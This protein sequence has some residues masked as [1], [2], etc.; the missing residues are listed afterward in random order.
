LHLLYCGSAR[1]RA[2][3][4]IWHMI[5][6]L[7]SAAAVVWEKDDPLLL[8]PNALEYPFSDHGRAL[9]YP[10]PDLAAG[11]PNA[12]AVP[13]LCRVGSVTGRYK[14]LFLG[15]SSVVLCV[16]CSLVLL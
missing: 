11:R 9:E 3:L 16:I 8:S 15:P 13:R 4:L 1:T 5:Y 6:L 2:C 12:V 7:N 10:C 14:S